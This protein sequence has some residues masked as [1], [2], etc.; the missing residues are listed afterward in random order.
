MGVGSASPVLPSGGVKVNN[1]LCLKQILLYDIVPKVAELLFSCAN[2][3][4]QTN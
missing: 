3:S 2:L 4:P 1:F